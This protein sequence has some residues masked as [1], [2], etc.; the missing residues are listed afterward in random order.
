M[1]A[2]SL[3]ESI[4]KGELPSG[5]PLRQD[6]IAER[7]GVS[8]IPV[9]EALREL[10]A[11]GLVTIRR[12]RGSV[13]SELAP[14]EARQL[15][16]IR[17]AL[18]TQGLR[19]ALPKIDPGVIAGARQMLDRMERTREGRKWMQLN[20][21][22]H[23]LL[24]ERAARPMLFDMVRSLN[25]KVERYIRL[26]QASIDNRRQAE[27]EHRAILAACEVGNVEAACLL[28][29]QH[30]TATANQL[31]ELLERY[32]RERAQPPVLVEA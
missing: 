26:V 15:L 14:F 19:W 10:A 12:N 2:A 31:E 18:E 5:L 21:A 30:L 17:C 3:R 28:L 1:V 27:L 22:F 32:R 13:V 7:F 16:E 9:R 6:S 23:A 4:L 11:E 8:H 20:W 29:N 25:S 24:Y